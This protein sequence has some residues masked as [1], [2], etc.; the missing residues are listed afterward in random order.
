MF[1]YFFSGSSFYKSSRE[2]ARK[3]FWDFFSIYDI[4]FG[5]F[6]CFFS[7]SRGPVFINRAATRREIFFGFFFH[8]YDIR[9]CP[10]VISQEASFFLWGKI[11][12]FAVLEWCRLSCWRCRNWNFGWR[13]LSDRKYKWCR[14]ASKVAW[15][16]GK[17]NAGPLPRQSEVEPTALPGLRQQVVK[18]SWK[19]FGEKNICRRCWILDVFP[20]STAVWGAASCESTLQKILRK[21]YMSA[22]LDFG[23][24]HA[25]YWG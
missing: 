1:V 24:L 7:C 23:R 6:G 17:A 20:L 18:A 2:A 10:S 5:P 16:G 25:K 12:F 22:I 21:K 19:T 8:I 11:F 15:Q 13:R 9:F 4:R 14:L 3:N